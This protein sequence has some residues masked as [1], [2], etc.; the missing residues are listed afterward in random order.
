MR[1]LFILISEYIINISIFLLYISLRR[2]GDSE[3]SC[4]GL[5]VTQ[6]LPGR[7][8]EKSTSHF[9]FP[10]ITVIIFKILC[11]KLPN[12]QK[13]YINISPQS[14]FVCQ[15]PNSLKYF[16]PKIHIT[17]HV[18]I[19]TGIVHF[20]AYIPRRP[21]G[22]EAG[23]PGYFMFWSFILLLPGEKSFRL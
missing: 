11:Y 8:R 10:F 15:F 3:T 5:E 17:E 9:R 4:E 2:K 21:T 18:N 12:S 16:T 23:Q 19:I 6:L 1:L 20:K 14:Y 22:Q 13:L 7:G